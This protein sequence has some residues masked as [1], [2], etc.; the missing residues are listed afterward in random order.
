MGEIKDIEVSNIFLL[1]LAFVASLGFALTLPQDGMILKISATIFVIGIWVIGLCFHEFSHAL[2]SY[3]FG[4][5]SIIDKGYLSLNPLLFSDFRLSII[6]PII[7]LLIGGLPLPGGAVY[8]RHDLLKTRTHIA[9]TYLA[10]PFA[11]IIL[12]IVLCLL[13]IA[14]PDGSQFLNLK[15][16][17]AISAFFQFYSAIFNLLPIPSFD[18]FGALAV[19]L[20]PDI[21][22]KAQKIGA[23]AFAFIIFAVFALPSFFTPLARLAVTSVYSFGVPQEIM[24]N[25]FTNFLRGV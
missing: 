15:G 20:P 17:I 21:Q 14:L 2:S 19:F 25:G 6:F 10:G 9:L 13:I 11:N 8:L 18:G 24:E 12:G 23:L 1:L 16:A 5:T 7:I 3:I 22:I 4:D